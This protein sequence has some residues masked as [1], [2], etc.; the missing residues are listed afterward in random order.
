MR[1]TIRLGTV[2]LLAAILTGCAAGGAPVGAPGVTGQASSAGQATSS[3]GGP[4]RDQV[5]LIDNLRGRGVKAEPS[6]TAE[7][8]FLATAG[9]RLRLSGDGLN[10]PATIESYEYD[11]AAQANADAATIESDG[12]PR[13]SRITWMA[14][15]HFYRSERLIVLYVGA[16]P[17]VTKLLAGLLGPQFAGR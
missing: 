11:G 2:F 14:P 5:D 16:D 1:S 17:A 13:T 6:G 12:N 3:H 9:T 8:P 15:P 10:G 4:V 7:Q